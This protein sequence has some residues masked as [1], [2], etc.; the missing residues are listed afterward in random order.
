MSNKWSI[1]AFVTGVVL[2]AFVLLAPFMHALFE[3]APLNGTQLLA[4]VGLAF[5][6]TLIIQI[7]KMIKEAIAK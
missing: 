4:I 5:L 1:A 7:E 3:V 6:P 2:L